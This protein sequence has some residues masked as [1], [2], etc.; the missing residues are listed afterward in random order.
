MIVSMSMEKELVE[1]FDRAIKSRGY[2]TRSEAM[3][4]LVRNFISDC[5][6]DLE[7]EESI[8][9]ITL[10]YGKDVKKYKLMAIQH[11]YPEIST[12]MHTHVEDGSC[13]EVYVVK[14][15]GD[16]IRS[17]LSEFRGLAGVKAVK[18]VRSACG[19]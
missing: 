16:R 19:V 17:L 7:E 3:R 18:F 5:E 11:S 9:V 13:L 2:S 14:G 10:L 6:W 4:D 12:M 1:R 8:A 15:T